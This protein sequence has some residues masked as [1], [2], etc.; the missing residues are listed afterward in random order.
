MARRIKKFNSE[1]NL[2][3]QVVDYLKLNYPGI[4][5]RTDFAA[6]AKMTLGQAVKHAKLQAGPGYPDI[7]IIAPM[8]KDKV[9]DFY[10]LF[11]ELKKEGTKLVRE[12]DCTKLLKG[13]Y[14]L[15]L[16]GDWWD[17]HTEQQA[18]N[19]TYLKAN[20]YCATFAIGFEAAKDVIDKYLAGYKE[21]LAAMREQ[22]LLNERQE[23]S[24][25]F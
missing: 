23:E 25:V 12:K 15:R 6:G 10:A 24:E 21:Q 5:F 19:L 2:H 17:L 20:G 7:Q 9:A 18:E 8:Y 14:K 16:K 4:L 3:Q 11:I 1:E 13:D 22:Q